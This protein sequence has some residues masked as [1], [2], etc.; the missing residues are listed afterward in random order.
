MGVTPVRPAA[1]LSVAESHI[2]PYAENRLRM[3][4]KSKYKVVDGYMVRIRR[5][6]KLSPTRQ[7]LAD[8]SYHGKYGKG[9]PK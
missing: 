2:I 9:A 4:G 6:R 7:F 5:P 3:S 1:I 8:H